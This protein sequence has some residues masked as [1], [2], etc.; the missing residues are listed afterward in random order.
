MHYLIFIYAYISYMYAIFYINTYVD[1]YGY[2]C[3]VLPLIYIHVQYV[4]CI[5]QYI[6][7]FQ[8]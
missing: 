8:K 4:V 5:L 1:N 6:Y 2:M 3:T 7:K